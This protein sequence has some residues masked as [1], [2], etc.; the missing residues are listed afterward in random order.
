MGVEYDNICVYIYNSIP[1]PV[2]RGLIKIKATLSILNI[3]MY[4]HA[5]ICIH[6]HIYMYVGM[7]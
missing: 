4:T 2:K 5:Y 6:I 1:V 7:Y 3:R